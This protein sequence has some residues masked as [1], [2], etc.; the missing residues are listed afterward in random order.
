MSVCLAETKQ[1]NAA[2]SVSSGVWPGVMQEDTMEEKQKEK[3]R[4]EMI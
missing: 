1:Q 4:K 2:I 3:L